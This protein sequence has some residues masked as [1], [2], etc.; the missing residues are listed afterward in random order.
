MYIDFGMRK[1]VEVIHQ[2]SKH[3]Q[4][5]GGDNDC[6]QD[7]ARLFG[8]LSASDFISLPEEDA[9]VRRVFSRRSRPAGWHFSIYPLYSDRQKRKCSTGMSQSRQR[10]RNEDKR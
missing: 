4:Y 9:L 6:S 1:N 8:C 3:E 7:S 10:K 5:D 2:K